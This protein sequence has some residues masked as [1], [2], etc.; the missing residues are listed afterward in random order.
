MLESVH[1]FR[2]MTNLLKNDNLT[3]QAT[4][5]HINAET[6]RVNFYEDDDI[7][8]VLMLKLL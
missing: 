5:E 2:F 7:K 3:L 6:D 8:D 4:A 1:H